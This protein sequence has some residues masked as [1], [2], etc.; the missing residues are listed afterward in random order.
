MRVRKAHRVQK[1][2]RIIER[3]YGIS[4]EAQKRVRIRYELLGSDVA[5]A[6][7]TDYR[8]GVYAIK[9]ARQLPDGTTRQMR[10]ASRKGGF[11]SLK[12]QISYFETMYAQFGSPE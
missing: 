9:V 7:V 8:S 2:A 10:K 12:E 6:V 3:A 11:A 1:A 5:L 4:R